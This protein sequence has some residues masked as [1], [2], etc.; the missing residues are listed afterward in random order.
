MFMAGVQ[1]TCDRTLRPILS[2]RRDKHGH[3]VAG[4][5]SKVLGGHES[6]FFFLISLKVLGEKTPRHHWS[7]LEVGS[8]GFGL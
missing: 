4:T 5:T 3:E 8:A 6:E 2:L 7:A 1:P